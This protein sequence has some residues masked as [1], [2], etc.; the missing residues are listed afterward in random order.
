MKLKL[1]L[2]YR[3]FKLKSQSILNKITNNRYAIVF[4]VKENLLM[5]SINTFYNC[6]R[7]ELET[8]QKMCIPFFRDIKSMTDKKLN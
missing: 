5:V 7:F 6:I 2:L 3:L 8:V 1:I 4:N